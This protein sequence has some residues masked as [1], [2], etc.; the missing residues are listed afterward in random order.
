MKKPII[1]FLISLVAIILFLNPVLAA[2]NCPPPAPLPSVPYFFKK[3]LTYGPANPEKITVDKPVELKVTGGTSPYYWKISDPGGYN[4][5]RAT[6]TA[7]D[8]NNPFSVNTVTAGPNASN[9]SPL[10]ITVTDSTVDDSGEAPPNLFVSGILQLQPP[11]AWDYEK[12]DDEISGGETADLVVTGG[13]GIYSW[14]VSGEGYSLNS[15]ETESGAN[16][17]HADGSACGS[18]T[19]TVTSCDETVEGSVRGPNGRWV[20][21]ATQQ[22]GYNFAVSKGLGGAHDSFSYSWGDSTAF[23][24]ITGKYLLY[25]AFYNDIYTQRW[26]QCDGWSL[27]TAEPLNFGYGV[28]LLFDGIDLAWWIDVTGINYE[29]GTAY[30][31]CYDI[32]NSYTHEWRRHTLGHHYRGLLVYEWQCN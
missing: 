16:S 1:S 23:A 14:S 17:L 22:D 12:S 4:L 32:Y 18:A 20:V 5:E 31:A 7:A 24:K 9:E 29:C 13:C 10:Y 3:L 26:A 25:E 21:I 6:T 8:T 27:C 2:E 19:I 30:A 28:P 15:N 11:L